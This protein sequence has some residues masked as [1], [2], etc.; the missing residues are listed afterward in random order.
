M[1]DL[2][3]DFVP[4]FSEDQIVLYKSEVAQVKYYCLDKSGGYTGK[5]CIAQNGADKWF[6][7]GEGELSA[8]S[9]KVET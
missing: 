4:K 6:N 9:P 2:P 8:L 5:V 1:K 3:K 7:V